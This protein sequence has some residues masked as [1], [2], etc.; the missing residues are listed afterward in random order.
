MGQPDTAL[1]PHYKIIQMPVITEKAMKPAGPR[2]RD[3][4][5]RATG[6][7][8]MQYVFWVDRG[9]TKTQI[10][11]AVEK[12]FSVRVEK[13]RTAML[14]GSRKR[15]RYIYI[16]EPTRK[17]AMIILKDGDAIDLMG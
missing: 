8:R 11:H 16:N 13:V 15:W 5:G 7:H 17:K 14:K 1:E 4:S 3:R 12:I 2:D 6:D 9:A 10:R